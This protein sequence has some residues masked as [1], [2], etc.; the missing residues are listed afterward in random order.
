[1]KRK[2]IKYYKVPLYN[3]QKEFLAKKDVLGKYIPVSW[4]KNSVITAVLSAILIGGYGS[5]LDAQLN[6]NVKKE[7]LKEGKKQLDQNKAVNLFPPLFEHGEG[8]GAIGCIVTAPPVFISEADAREII[9]EECRKAGL[10][11]D[12]HDFEVK[13]VA[14]RERNER[15]IEVY[16][17]EKEGKEKNKK[18]TEE[19]KKRLEWYIERMQ[20]KM[21]KLDGYN[22]KI[23]FGY[24]FISNE[25]YNDVDSMRDENDKLDLVEM[26][27]VTEFNMKKAGQKLRNVLRK[28]GKF[29][30]VVFYDPLVNMLDDLGV[31]K[32]LSWADRRKI[33]GEKSR[34]LLRAQVLDFIDW[35][36]TNNLDGK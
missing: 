20:G 6:D 17:N 21:L 2:R 14:V 24:E 3:A 32:D 16:V 36:K 10:T 5:K 28:N 34:N 7:D 30:S 18:L 33:T 22:S 19:D 31:K 9:E 27:T 13:D 25:E 4:S 29:P 8:K 15:L 12:K 26:S 23:G 35:Y 1:M 11:F